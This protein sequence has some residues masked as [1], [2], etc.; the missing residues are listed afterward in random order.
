MAGQGPGH[1]G[2]VKRR[3]AC[4]AA[5]GR[6]RAGPPQDRDTSPFARAED[7]VRVHV[8]RGFGQIPGRG[9]RVGA[10]DGAVVTLRS[11]GGV[12]AE[13]FQRRITCHLARNAARGWITPEMPDCPL[14]VRGVRA[15]VRRTDAGL[16][17]T[18]RSRSPPAARE[19]AVRAKPLRADAASDA[20]AGSVT[21]WPPAA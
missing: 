14:A 2:P 3:P 15:S 9:L 4:C 17:V 13:S 11:V 5:G 1:L 16:A 8:L 18:M 21:L 10:T 7:I 6:R 12:T 19:I 20:P